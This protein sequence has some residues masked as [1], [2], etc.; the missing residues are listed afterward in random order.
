MKE[1]SL[2]EEVFDAITT[3]SPRDS[4]GLVF[5]VFREELAGRDGL[6]TPD[7]PGVRKRLIRMAGRY[8][9]LRE[10]GEEPLLEIAL[11]HP[12]QRQRYGRLG[13]SRRTK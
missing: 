8:Q 11:S 1:P 12:G 2:A 6:N 4:I 7:V 9:V 5:S 3:R 13:R 10:T